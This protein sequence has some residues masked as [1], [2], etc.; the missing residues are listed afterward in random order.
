MV[1]RIAGALLAIALVGGCG[2]AVTNAATVD[3]LEAQGVDPD[4]IYEVDVPGYTPAA[5]SAGVINEDGFGLSYRSSE[6][7]GIVHLRIDRSAFDDARCAEFP[8]FD[9]ESG[10][11]V[12]CE[13]DESGWFRTGGGRHEYALLL[14][15]HLLRLNAPADALDEYALRTALLEARPL[16]GEPPR[17]TRRP[18]SPVPR[19]DL[20][21]VGDG[22]PHN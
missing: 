14:G 2:N 18:L 5:Q 8:I 19:G 21:S 11:A 15:D 3:R 6:R 22:A 16:R 10:S 4:L 12:R 13:P 20:P 9:A 17:P 7:G 1:V